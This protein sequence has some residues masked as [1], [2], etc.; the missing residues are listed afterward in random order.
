MADELE[1]EDFDTAPVGKGS[2]APKEEAAPKKAATRKPAKKK[3]T[4]KIRLEEND[5]IPPTGLFVSHNGRGYLIKVGEE[6]DIPNHVLEILRNA[7]IDTPVVDPQTRRVIG[8]RPRMKY[9]FTVL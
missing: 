2:I 1:N 5:D 9:P 7:R 4:T 6:V 8:Y 3:T